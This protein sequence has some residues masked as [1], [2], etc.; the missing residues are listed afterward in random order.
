MYKIVKHAEHQMEIQDYPV[1]LATVFVLLIILILLSPFLSDEAT[2]QGMV[3]GIFIPTTGLLIFKKRRVLIDKKLMQMT[4]E[5]RNIFLSKTETYSLNVMSRVSLVYQ[6]VKSNN[7]NVGGGRRNSWGSLFFILD[8]N[9]V[10]IVDS[11]ICFGHKKKLLKLM[12][13]CNRW[14]ELPSE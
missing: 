9:K 14:S 7:I 4:C 12:H 3:I 6:V 11:D 1:C 5:E 10:K 2:L 8:D 13:Q